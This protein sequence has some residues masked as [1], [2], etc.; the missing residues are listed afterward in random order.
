MASSAP[1]PDPGW[2]QG[3]RWT[4]THLLPWLSAHLVLIGVALMAVGLTVL[5]WR[6]GKR[7][8]RPGSRKR[9]QLR[10]T[11]SAKAAPLVGYGMATQPPGGFIDW[12]H[13]VSKPG[14]TVVIHYP[15]GW[16]A[17][18]SQTAPV[19]EL[20]V[21]MAGGE[22]EAHHDHVARKLC[23]VRKQPPAELPSTLVYEDDPTG[24]VDR[25]RF[26]Q[27]AEGEW[28]TAELTDLTPMVLIAAS[29]GWGKSSTARMFVAHVAAH[30]GLIDVVDPKR[31]SLAEFKGCPPIRYWT[32]TDE[33]V[34]VIADYRQEV[35]DRYRAM[36]TGANLL[37]REQFP[38]RLL[39]LEEAGSLMAMITQHWQENKP[40]G[41]PT[42]PPSIANLM[43]I[44]WQG[45]A[46][47][48]HVLTAAQQANAKVLISS[49]GR[50][51]YALR[52]LAGPT[53]TNSWGMIF[54]DEPVMA[55]D[56][57]KGR[58][59]V[60]IGPEV[61]R[62]QIARLDPS[63][64]RQMALR[65][66]ARFP[67]SAPEPANPRD[68]VFNPP[69]YSAPEVP[70]EPIHTPEPVAVPPEPTKGPS[71]IGRPPDVLREPVAMTCKHCNT[72]WTTRAAS[73]NVSVC[74]SCKKGRRVPKRDADTV[75]PTDGT[76]WPDPLQLVCGDCG[77]VWWSRAAGGASSTCVRCGKYTRVPARS[78][79][80]REA[81]AYQDR[82]ANAKARAGE[83]RANRG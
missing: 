68:A 41:G 79:A 47:G 70:S 1:T 12:P 50:D 65:G 55:T 80:E 66:A 29:T 44:L 53:S 69:A 38:L 39:V 57:M 46:A 51:Q 27:N 48:M 63:D 3:L 15:E 60:G 58:A 61:T 19:K 83:I 67:G 13:D 2:M 34:R 32:E 9:D 36:E 21:Q 78:E 30:G 71:V 18:D 40:R 52:I 74:P 8:R 75:A 6:S 33:F 73:G 62:V 5:A 17:L 54:G 16:P 23:Y 10:A 37:D 49:D 24:S 22:W 7:L 31:I 76:E 26:A 20:V 64:A 42:Q 77:H 81:T 45:R 25:I 35:E 59:V 43:R 14:S 11:L 4:E 82:M 72:S 56:P 28:I